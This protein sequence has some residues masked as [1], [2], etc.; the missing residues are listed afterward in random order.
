MQST[1][2]AIVNE[3]HFLNL[4]D[5]FSLASVEPVEENQFSSELDDGTNS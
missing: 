1:P 3:R 2:E 4:K 5:E